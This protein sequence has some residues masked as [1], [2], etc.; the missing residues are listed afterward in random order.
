MAKTCQVQCLR[1][2]TRYRGLGEGELERGVGA[3]G[4][5]SI[6]P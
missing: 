6:S 1:G 2:D 4:S 3:Q 5:L